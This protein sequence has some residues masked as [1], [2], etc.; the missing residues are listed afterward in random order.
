MRRLRKKAKYVLTAMG[1]AASLAIVMGVDHSAVKNQLKKEAAAS[2]VQVEYGETIGDLKSLF[3]DTADLVSVSGNIDPMT[4]GSYPVELTLKR[5]DHFGLSSTVQSE[6][7]VSVVDTSDPVI[8][9]AQSEVVVLPDEDDSTIAEHVLSV[10][11]PIDGALEKSDTLAPGTWTIDAQSDSSQAIVEAMDR[12]G[13]VNTV[14]FPVKRIEVPD[15]ALPYSIRINRAANTV[16]VYLMDENQ[17]YS[18]PIKAMVCSTGTATPLGSYS[19]TEKYRWRSLFGGVYG[20]YA[21]RI[22]GNI[23]FHSVPYFSPDPGNLEYLEYNKLGTKASMGCIRLCVE[24]EKWIYDNCPIGTPVEL[25][26]DEDNPGPLGKPTPVTIDV[27]D[28]RRGWD[29]TDPDENNPWHL[30]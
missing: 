24:D 21:C 4:V 26:D 17:E 28:E 14:T 15:V 19:I 12:N 18:I 3:S 30:D 22:V 6:A 9:L 5:R 25:Y 23:L 11:D 29:P 13:N 10:S 2:S 20:Q 8:E 1:A 27:N 7:D 16:T